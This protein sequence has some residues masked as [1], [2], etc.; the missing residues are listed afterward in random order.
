MNNLIT[1]DEKRAFS[2]LFLE[3]LGMRPASSD[4]QLQLNILYD[5]LLFGINKKHSARLQATLQ[6]K[7]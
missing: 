7:E 4:L 2:Y 3:P 1:I 5:P 6:I